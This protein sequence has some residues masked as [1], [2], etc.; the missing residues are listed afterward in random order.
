MNK[1]T[2]WSSLEPRVCESCGMNYFHR[3]N[4]EKAFQFKTR[5]FCGKGCKMGWLS[6]LNQGKKAHNN[7]RISRECIICH[8]KKEVSPSL[9]KRHF[10]SRKCMGI[11]MSKT[12]RG[13][14]HWN[15][16]GGKLE[17]NCLICGKI[18]EFDKGDIRRRKVSRL[19]CS[20]KCK[21]RYYSEGKRNPNWRGGIQPEHLKIR[22]SK[23]VRDWKLK[24][25][26][27]D[28][29][30]CQKCNEIEGLHIHHIIPFSKNKELRHSLEN[31]ITLCRRCHYEIHRRL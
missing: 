30:R 4:T 7:K 27:R 28:D 2:D 20:I 13:K 14:N 11:W 29:Y 26:E 5:R 25:L 24:C 9:S 31:G 6:K 8:K 15:W 22:N 23:E 19:F 21:A 1:K 18:F 17:R 10:C 16:N 3:G 12:N